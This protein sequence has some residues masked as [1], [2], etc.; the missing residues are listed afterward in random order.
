MIVHQWLHFRW[1]PARW[2]VGH[3]YIIVLALPL[4]VMALVAVLL[5]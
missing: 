1:F 2:Q 3:D 5:D 4:R